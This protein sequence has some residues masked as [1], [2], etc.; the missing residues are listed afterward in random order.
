M[1]S[2]LDSFVSFA[3]AL[4]ESD[5]PDPVGARLVEVVADTLA[6]AVGGRSCVASQLAKSVRSIPTTRVLAGR[7]IGSP[8]LASAE[9]AAFSN[10][11]MIRCLDFND[12]SPPPSSG[13][14]SD[15]IGA[16]LA[17]TGTTRVTGRSLIRAVAIA[18]EIYT[19]LAASIQR[20]PRTIE[21]GYAATVGATAACGV[22]IGLGAD[23][24]RAAMA[25]AASS[26]VPLRATR[27]GQLSNYKGVATAVSMRDAVLFCLLARE[28]MTGPEA[29]FEGKH[30]IVELLERNPGRLEVEPFGEWKTLSTRLKYWPVAYNMQPSIEAAMRLR[31]VV[32]HDE[33]ESVV[34]HA[35]TFSYNISGSEVEK[36]KPQTSETADH[37]LPYVFA[38]AFVYGHIDRSSFA[39]EALGDHLTLKL[40]SRVDVVEDESAD[41]DTAHV[42]LTTRSGDHHDESVRGCPGH[43]S[44]PLTRSQLADKF[45]HLVIP[46]LSEG[47]ASKAFQAVLGTLEV[48]DFED[49]L[50]AF[51]VPESARNS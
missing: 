37:S 5:I 9:F 35:D 43:Q 46:A 26:G 4:D 24:L 36:W 30:G 50:R 13:H 2:V 40:M 45:G 33:I 3:S 39:Q 8:E 15:M 41:D 27:A 49:V 29:P 17:L 23:Q 47:G 16:I 42:V 20:R 44:N 7:V 10:T 11:V 25:M 34:I 14:P 38:R 22:L 6:C 48:A 21:M 28:G 31:K 51:D 19:R 18:Y 1:D 32:S 12:S